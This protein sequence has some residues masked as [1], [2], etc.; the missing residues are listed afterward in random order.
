MN[1]FNE[2]SAETIESHIEEDFPR[3]DELLFNHFAWK[4]AEP[5]HRSIVRIREKQPKSRHN[6]YFEIFE[7]PG[8]ERTTI[9]CPG[10]HSIFWGGCIHWFDR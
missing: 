2:D 7:I 4:T 5:T 8:K 1:A 6:E 3:E 9:F 10:K